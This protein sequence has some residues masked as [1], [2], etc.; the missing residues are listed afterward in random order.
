VETLTSA[1]KLLF[2][3]WVATSPKNKLPLFVPVVVIAYKFITIRHKKESSEST[4]E[5]K[6]YNQI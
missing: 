2:F 5:N 6:L 1:V 3:T 4:H